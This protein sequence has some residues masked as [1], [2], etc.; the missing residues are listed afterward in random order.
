MAEQTGV[1][2]YLHGE[3]VVQGSLAAYLSASGYFVF[4]SEMEL[5]HAEEVTI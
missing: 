5:A 2:D 1:R 4:H 3:K